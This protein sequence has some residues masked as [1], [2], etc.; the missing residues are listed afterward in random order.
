MAKFNIIEESKVRA[1]N[2]SRVPKYSQALIG[3]AAVLLC[4]N[5]VGKGKPFCHGMRFGGVMK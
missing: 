1:K 2:S 4:Q 3:H 5:E